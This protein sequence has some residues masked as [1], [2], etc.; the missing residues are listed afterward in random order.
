MTSKNKKNLS[1]KTRRNLIIAFIAAVLLITVISV[2]LYLRKKEN[3]RSVRIAFC[4]IS[5]ELSE[6]IEKEIPEIDGIKINYS[7][8]NKDDIDLGVV[9]EK[10]DLL[11]TWSGE[12]SDTLGK[13]SE[14]IPGKF[15]QTVPTSLR[16]KKQYPIMLDHYEMAFYSPVSQNYQLDFPETWDDLT[17]YLKEASKHVFT[18]FICEGSNDRTLLSLLGTI[19]EARGG[20]ESYQKFID[21][22]KESDKL[23]DILEVE[24]GS[25]EEGKLTLKSVLEMLKQWADEGLVHPLWYIATRNDIL[26]FMEDK[27]IA[28]LFDSLTEHRTIPYSI[29]K[30]YESMRVPADYSRNHG[31][32]SPAVV[33][34]QLSNNLNNDDL[35]KPFTMEEVQGRLSMLSKLGPTQYRAE[36]YDRQADDVRFWAAS[37]KYGALPDISLAV[38]QRNSEGMKNFAAEIRAYYKSISR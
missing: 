36:S 22:L 17:A 24:L 35:I 26:Y 8:L 27:Q 31:V 16:N 2:I 12:I 5:Q 18:P 30:D 1:K 10:F 29:I 6:I 4:G 15:L 19:I 34:L 32:I 28:V 3:D 25:V 9:S 20:L 21:S 33:C 14:D 38:Y 13:F 37:C 7:Y 23:E 11:F